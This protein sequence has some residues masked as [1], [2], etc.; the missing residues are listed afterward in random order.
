MICIHL[1]ISLG[2]LSQC[3]YRSCYSDVSKQVKVVGVPQIS[4]PPSHWVDQRT[5]GE[6]CIAI[7]FNSP[8]QPLSSA[9][10][11][12]TQDAATVRPYTHRRIPLSSPATCS[13]TSTRLAV[14]ASPTMSAP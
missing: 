10:T 2:L 5:L 6:S 11:L 9:T 7:S 14:A 12:P 13:N 4:P 1:R 3:L 8:I